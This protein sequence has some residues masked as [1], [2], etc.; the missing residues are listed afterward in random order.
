M[1]YTCP[2]PPYR[3]IVPPNPNFFYHKDLHA[4]FHSDVR[5]PLWDSYRHIYQSQSDWDYQFPKSAPFSLLLYISLY[6]SAFLS[7]FLTY[8]LYHT[9]KQSHHPTKLNPISK[10]FPSL[11]SLCCFLSLPL[12]N[13]T[14]TKCEFPQE[15]IKFS[16]LH[17]TREESIPSLALFQLFPLLPLPQPAHEYTTQ[18]DDRYTQYNT[19]SIHHQPIYHEWILPLS[20]ILSISAF[21]LPF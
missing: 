10:W 19:Y 17:P 12:S 4:S 13:H 18:K 16:Q 1:Q 5:S 21:Q 2:S 15:T 7:P 11:F 20:P 9:P 8:I 3:S 14:S 6:S